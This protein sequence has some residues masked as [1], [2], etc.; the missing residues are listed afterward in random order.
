MI[1]TQNR[2]C[3][4]LSLRLCTWDNS[5][6]NGESIS[7]N[8]S[9]RPDYYYLP[10]RQH[11]GY[12]HFPPTHFHCDATIQHVLPVK[13]KPNGFTIKIWG[14]CVCVGGGG[15]Y[16]SFNFR[17]PVWLNINISYGNKIIVKM[18]PKTVLIPFPK[19]LLLKIIMLLETDNAA[20][21][22]SH[23]FIFCC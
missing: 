23:C 3:P 15:G 10:L 16:A 5:S 19:I 2:F 18:H 4:C 11:S 6:F 8:I 17:H 14:R 1:S 22:N 12:S 7:C 20:V 21:G 13:P 9:L